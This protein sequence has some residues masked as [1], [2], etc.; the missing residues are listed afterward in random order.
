MCGDV[1]LGAPCLRGKIDDKE[2]NWTSVV[3]SQ[4]SVAVTKYLREST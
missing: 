2:A 1:C 3:I 4:F